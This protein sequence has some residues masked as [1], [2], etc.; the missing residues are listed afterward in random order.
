MRKSTI[1][2]IVIAIAL[3]IPLVALIHY[4]TPKTDIVRI[5]GVNVIRVDSDSNNSQDVSGATRDVYE[6]YAESL[7]KSQTYVYENVDAA[8]YLKF[9]SATVQSKAQAIANE[10]QPEDRI[11]GVTNIGWRIPIISWFPNALDVKRA[12]PG[13]FFF[14]VLPTIFWTVVLLIVG[15]AW[16]AIARF[17][18]RRRVARE[19]RAEAARLRQ[20]AEARERVATQAGKNQS[21][22]DAADRFI[23]G[24]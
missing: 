22:T 4:W 15:S 12:Q 13:D 11:A 17:K 3:L 10:Q 14:P 23:N 6:I 16:F 8:L 2:K 1:V 18:N 9:D 19:A 20:E 5:T 24:D 7:D 21:E